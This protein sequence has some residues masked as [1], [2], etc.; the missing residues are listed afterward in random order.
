MNTTEPLPRYL[1][2]KVVCSRVNK[3]FMIEDPTSRTIKF[4]QFRLQR[5]V[6][7]AKSEVV[8]SYE[9]QIFCTLRHYTQNIMC[10]YRCIRI[11]ISTPINKKPQTLK[12]WKYLVFTVLVYNLDAS[13]GMF[14]MRISF[15]LAQEIKR[16]YSDAYYVYIYAFASLNGLYL[17]IQNE[18]NH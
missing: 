8:Y 3:D 7:L 12:T 5:K 1:I 14:S 9:M 15:T 10:I 4:I 2:H 16:K 6:K 11:Y 18:H 17:L 13:I